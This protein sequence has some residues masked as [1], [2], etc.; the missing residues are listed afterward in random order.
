MALGFIGGE[1]TGMYKGIL[2][3]DMITTVSTTNKLYC[4]VYIPAYWHKT[5]PHPLTY[6]PLWC[7]SLPLKKGDEVYVYF[8]D[9]DLSL[10]VLWKPVNEPNKDEYNFTKQFSPEVTSN[11]KPLT[12]QR[13]I[14]AYRL[15]ENSYVIK[16]DNYT[17]FHQNDGYVLV[18]KE[19]NIYMGGNT[20]NVK[21][22]DKLAVD[23]SGVDIKTTG[24]FE[25]NGPKTGMLKLS[26][27][28][29]LKDVV[30]S[31]IDALSSLIDTLNSGTII[32]S[33]SPASQI[34]TPGQFVKNVAEVKT[35]TGT[36]EALMG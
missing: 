3:E 12:P 5:S 7:M 14:G 17:V 8:H 22:K 25:W 23:V 36:V 15:G 33:G 19:N 16:T 32:T 31:I 27:G 1:A 28:T 13:T 11:G 30:Q 10:P 29:S 4:D 20:I 2:N 24:D 35:A 6:V 21:G 9:G 18:D 26:N 34:I